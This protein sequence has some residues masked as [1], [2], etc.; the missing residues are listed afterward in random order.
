[1]HFFSAPVRRDIIFIFTQIAFKKNEEFESK[2]SASSKSSYLTAEQLSTASSSY[3]TLNMAAELRRNAHLRAA[4][5]QQQQTADLSQQQA[6]M[7]QK[8]G[9]QQKGTE[10]RC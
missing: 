3:Q 8:H 2:G 1:M 6:R 4:Q 5:Q 10:I 7:R 9:S